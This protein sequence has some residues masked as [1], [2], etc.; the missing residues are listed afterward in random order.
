LV[1]WPAAQVSAVVA[2]APVISF[3]S[4]AYVVV[5][6]WWPN[7]IKAHPLSSLSILGIIVIVG[8]VATMQLLPH[9]LKKNTQ[10]KQPN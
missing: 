3:I 10:I 8:S 6:G 1:Y 4:T 5:M 7:I 2:V 9:L